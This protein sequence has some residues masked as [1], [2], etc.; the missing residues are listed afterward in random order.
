MSSVV[1]MFAEQFPMLPA[2][3]CGAQPC[4]GLEC[5]GGGFIYTGAAGFAAIG[6]VRRG[7]G[8]AL[9]GRTR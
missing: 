2:T 5:S 8:N 3:G 7:D 6:R 9:D 4:I 1:R